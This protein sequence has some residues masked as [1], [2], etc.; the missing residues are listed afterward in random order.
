M[1][2]RTTS[3]GVVRYCYEC[4]YLGEID[5][6]RRDCCPD[7]SHA[8]YVHVEVA[9]QAKAG[10]DAML[11]SGHSAN[12]EPTTTTVSWIPIGKRLPDSCVEVLVTYL[13]D[14]GQCR[15]V[16]VA[17]YLDELVEWYLEDDL[18]LPAEH[19]IAWAELPKAFQDSMPAACPL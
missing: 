12:T 16:S 19:V 4:G 6:K 8:T 13:S 7:G 10:F 14:C 15:E 9:K 3:P 1:R 5:S 17:Y 2:T 11:H 18:V